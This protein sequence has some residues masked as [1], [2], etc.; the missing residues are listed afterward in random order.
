[1]SRF[2]TIFVLTLLALAASTASAQPAIQPTADI[3]K[4]PAAAQPTPQFDA[5]AATEAYMELMPPAAVA[6]SNAYFEGGYW[7][8]LWDFLYGAAVCLVLLNLRWSARMRDLSLRITRFRW[9]QPLPYAV[10]YTLAATILGFPL[11][12]YENYVREHKYGLATQTFGPWMGDEFK[13]LLVSLVISSIAMVGLFAIVRRFP[14]TWWIWGAAATLC[15]LT[16][17]IAIGPV[18]L[19]PIFNTPKKLDDPKITT[20]ILR[21]A[22]AN[23]IP[24]NDVWQIDASRQTTRMSANVSGFGNTMRITL[25]DNLIRRGSPEEIQAVMGHEMGHYVLNHIPK[26]LMFFLIVIV[27]SFA[28]LFWGIKWSLGRWGERWQIHSI[29]D[30]AVV[31]LVVLLVAILS[32]VATPI[33]NTFVRVQ[34][35]E[36]DMF[37]LNASR[38]PDGFAQA[39]IHLG[40]YR[41]MRPSPIEELLF[42]DHPSGYNRIHSAMV[43]KS[44]NLD[45]VTQEPK[46]ASE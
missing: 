20:P 10:L 36:A 1:M 25:N 19:Q 13:S 23:G 45:L 30:P 3:T 28:Y 40:E 22:H 43:W 37:G 46:R 42:Y 11:E 31:P 6:R 8:I 5:D 9:L 26:S 38:L 34:E 39:A 14:K 18:Y 16:I 41:K 24:T 15:L 33:N 12:Y 32:F 27:L 35:K 2:F 44:Q 17:L 7:L 4:V 21:M 29:G